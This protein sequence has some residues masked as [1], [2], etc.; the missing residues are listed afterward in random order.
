VATAVLA[1]LAAAIRH[2]APAGRPS[3]GY[4]RITPKEPARR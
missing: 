1:R 4:E 2:T 3:A